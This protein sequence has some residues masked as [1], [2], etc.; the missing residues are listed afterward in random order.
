MCKPVKGTVLK[1]KNGPKLSLF[2]LWFTSLRYAFLSTNH[3]YFEPVQK[4]AEAKLRRL[5]AGSTTG[6]FDMIVQ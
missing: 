1:N 5:L 3:Y 4:I 2:V 6:L